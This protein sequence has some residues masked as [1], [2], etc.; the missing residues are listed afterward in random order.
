MEQRLGMASGLKESLH[1]DVF[2]AS[3]A[4]EHAVNLHR[5]FP[6]NP[7]KDSPRGLLNLAPHAIAN[8]A[9]LRWS[10]AALREDVKSFAA[11]NDA[12]E[13]LIGTERHFV[14]QVRS[15]T[16]DVTGGDLRT[17]DGVPSLAHRLAAFSSAALARRRTSAVEWTRPVLTSE[18]W[19]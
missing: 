14:E 3:P 7:V 18:S 12:V 9:Q 13:D 5:P 10:A 8:G 1:Q 15:Q 11:G 4:V 17:D 6:D 16:L 2:E 19:L